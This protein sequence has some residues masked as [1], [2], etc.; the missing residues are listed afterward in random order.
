MVKKAKDIEVI[1]ESSSDEDDSLCMQKRVSKQQI[2]NEPTQRLASDFLGKV[3]A[4]PATPVIKE[5][6]AYVL[7]PARKAQFEKARL[8]REDNIAR[9][10][11]IRDEEA[12]KHELFKNELLK[13]K[14]IK[15][16][17][18]KEKEIKALIVSDSDSSDSEVIVKKKKP[19]KAK[20]KKKKVVYESSSESESGSEL[21]SDHEVIIKKHKHPPVSQNYPPSK[22][23]EVR[24]IIQYF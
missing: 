5:R 17:K 4:S 19:H 24:R 6:K 2:V 22:P 20:P 13:K 7:T 18:K 12:E 10:N 15:S 9:K 16:N 21:E 11:A 23:V 1:E 8:I 3:L 14:E